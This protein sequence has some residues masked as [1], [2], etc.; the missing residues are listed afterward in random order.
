MNDQERTSTSRQGNDISNNAPWA[1]AGLRISSRTLQVSEIRL[2]IPRE[3]IRHGLNRDGSGDGRDMAFC[4]FAS[5]IGEEQPVEEHILYMLGLLEAAGTTL[6][7]RAKEGS[8]DVRL[9]C[10]FSAASGAYAITLS[11]EMIQRLGR[12]S[13]DFWITAYPPGNHDIDADRISETV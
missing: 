3:P 4:T 12:L 1:R 9:S 6:Q 8:V 7:Q 10:A 13:L 11:R 2:L 5:S